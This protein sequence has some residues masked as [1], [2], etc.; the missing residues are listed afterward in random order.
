VPVVRGVIKGSASAAVAAD[1]PQMRAGVLLDRDGTIIVD[2]GYVGSVERVELIEGSAE[3]IAS[4]NR[5]GVP[6]AVVTNQAGVA[7]GYYGTAD[8]EEVHEHLSGMLS[9]RGAHVDLFLYCPYHPDGTVPA[10]ARHSEDRKPA[11]GMAKAAAKA[12]HLDLSAC[13]VV[14]D[15]SE[16]MDL[17]TAIGAQAVWVGSGKPSRT[18]VPSFPNLAAAAPY[19]LAGLAVLRAAR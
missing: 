11:P 2:R 19:I 4:F 13:W 10:F 14:G 1:V 18:G 8:V 7:R 6:V 9:R 15:R 3:A 16:D 5:A 17:A 12:L